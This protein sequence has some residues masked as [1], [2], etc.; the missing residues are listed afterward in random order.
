M[1]ESLSMP[2]APSAQPPSR[3]PLLGASDGTDQ[4]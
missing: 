3:A 1:Q 2:C 4:R